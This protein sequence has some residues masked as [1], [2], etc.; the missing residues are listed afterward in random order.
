VLSGATE[1]H[2]VLQRERERLLAELRAVGI[3]L[4]G[5]YVEQ[6]DISAR[7]RIDLEG[8]RSRED[9]VGELFRGVAE[10]LGDEEARTAL[11]A[12]VLSGLDGLPQHL[13]ED[14]ELDELLADAER[15]LLGCFL[16][17]SNDAGGAEVARSVRREIEGA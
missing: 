13:R 4:G 10:V 6:V 12:E 17:G 8:L 1:A 14:Q 7:P 16:D 9:A 3:R 15:L 5:V 11:R 2:S